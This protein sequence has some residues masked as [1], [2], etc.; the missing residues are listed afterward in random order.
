MAL[1]PPGASLIVVIFVVVIAAAGSGSEKDGVCQKARHASLEELSGL[2]PASSFNT[3]QLEDRFDEELE[4]WLEFCWTTTDEDD[5]LDEPDEPEDWFTDDDWLTELVEEL[6]ELEPP[7]L[8]TV[9]C[10]RITPPFVFVWWTDL[11]FPD[12]RVRR[13]EPSPLV[14]RTSQSMLSPSPGL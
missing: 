3:C 2:I 4:D 6:T 5:W 7:E 10:I 11:S 13:R 12:S 9:N 8:S 1:R 14:F